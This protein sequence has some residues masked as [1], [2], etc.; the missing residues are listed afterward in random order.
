MALKVETYS[1]KSFVVRGDTRPYKTTLVDDLG[2]KWNPNLK[3]GGALIFSNKHLEE[4]TEI[5][6]QINLG[7]YVQS[8]SISESKIPITKS[9]IR[10]V[11][12]LLYEPELHEHAIIKIEPSDEL[13]TE[14]I[15]I[16]P[17]KDIIQLKYFKDTSMVFEAGNYAGNWQVRGENRKHTIVFE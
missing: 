15:S 4:V 2:G 10:K 17:N 7:T 11:E 1:D 6:D 5:V 3:G 16:N 13:H 14:V 8:L 12:Y 9:K